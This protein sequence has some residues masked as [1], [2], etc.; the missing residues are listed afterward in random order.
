MNCASAPTSTAW[1]SPSSRDSGPAVAKARR[2]ALDLVRGF[3]PHLVLTYH[4]YYKAP[5]LVGPHLARAGLPYFIFSGAYA[6]KRRKRLRT[7][8]GY[9]L[10]KRARSWPQTTSF[11]TRPR[12]TNA[13]AASFRPRATPGFAR[14]SAPGISCTIPRPGRRFGP[15][16]GRGT[17]RCWSLRRCCG[18]GS[19]C[20][21]SSSWS[22]AG[23]RSSAGGLNPLLVIAGDGPGRA[24]VE[25][26]ARET[27][28][29]S[30][31]FLG[32][33]DRGRLGEIFSAGDLFLFPGINEGLGMVYLEAQ[34]CG[35]PVV[36]TPPRRSRRGGCGTGKPG[37][38]SRRSSR[39][40]SRTRPGSC[41]T[42][43][44]RRRAMGEAAGRFVRQIH[45]MDANYAAMEAVM[46]D[47]VEKRKKR[48][49]C[50]AW[51]RL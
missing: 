29:E 51:L 13:W 49:G 6:E 43:P 32:M 10:N 21:A 1:R 4:T 16:G 5:D 30:V 26:L 36:A 31:R 48:A 37:C 46:L 39:G 11:P 22:V 41:W 23:P 33:A 15:S 8:P 40:F 3:R 44:A 18:P 12:T 28:P 47:V 42:T 34:S 27:G 20:G 14:E 9:L 50:R 38:W 25:A 19:R 2:E 45:D 7:L 35:L 24:E 17:G